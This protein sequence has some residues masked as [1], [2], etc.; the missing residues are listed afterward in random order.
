[1]KLIIDIPEEV[2]RNID[3]FKGHFLC[4]GGYDLIQAIKNG[5]PLNS[6]YDK[7]MTISQQLAFENEE[8]REKLSAVPEREKGEWITDNIDDGYVECPF[9]HSLTNCEWGKYDDLHFCFNCGADMR[10]GK[11]DAL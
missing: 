11:N 9:C 10:G 8:L 4:N 7:L 3:T 1:M 5:T 2:K 6:N